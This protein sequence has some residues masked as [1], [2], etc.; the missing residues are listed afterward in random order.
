MKPLK[1]IGLSMQAFET[2]VEAVREHLRDG[3]YVGTI[4]A[5]NRPS[6]SICSVNSPKINVHIYTDAE[7][8][9]LVRE[10]CKQWVHFKWL[11]MEGNREAFIEDPFEAFLEEYL[12]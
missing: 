5:M 7:R 11:I 2:S 9:E 12:K 3:L 6:P 10:V 1:E 8:R 4:E